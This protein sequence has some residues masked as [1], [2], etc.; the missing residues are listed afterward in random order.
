MER[1]GQLVHRIIALSLADLVR[2]REVISL[3]LLAVVKQLVEYL[4]S[5]GDLILLRIILPLVPIPIRMD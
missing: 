2:Q 1:T 3:V 5:M 4:V